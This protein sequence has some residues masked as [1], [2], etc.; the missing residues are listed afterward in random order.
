MKLIIGLGNPEQRY[1]GTRHNVGFMMLDAYATGHSLQFSGK[2]KFSA[3]IAEYVAEDEKVLL[4]KPTTYY[5]E[6]GQSVRALV[7]FYNLDPRRDVLVIHDDMALPFSTIRT[8]E[9]GSDAGNN[10]IKSLNSHIGPDYARVRIGIYNDLRERM[11]AADFVL[12]KF[13]QDENQQFPQIA[14]KVTDMIN[15]FIADHFTSTS[16]T[17]NSEQQKSA[18]E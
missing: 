8:R 17:S 12:A 3:E 7:D 4:V 5:N 9:K 15:D 18:S 6:S 13:S 2:T 14:E 10:G 16:H 11:D 1:H